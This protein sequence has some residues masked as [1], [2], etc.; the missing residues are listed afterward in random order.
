MHNPRHLQCRV[1]RVG[2]VRMPT[3]QRSQ[4]PETTHTPET[5]WKA[6]TCSHAKPAC[7]TPPRQR[8]AG[9][10]DKTIRTS[11]SRG[12]AAWRK[13]IQPHRRGGTS[14]LPTIPKHPIGLSPHKPNDPVQPSARNE[15][16]QG[17]Q[18]S[19]RVG[20]NGGLGGWA[21]RQCRGFMDFALFNHLAQYAKCRYCA[22]G[23]IKAKSKT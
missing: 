19:T 7:A 12:N 11:Q 6:G 20:W 8:R 10:K 23:L 16:E 22:D 14:L 15:P 2:S 17:C 18:T 4:K 3:R 9:A 5:L 13:R 1:R 21:M